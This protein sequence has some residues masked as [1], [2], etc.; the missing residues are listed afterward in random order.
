MTS[1]CQLELHDSGSKLVWPQLLT[2]IDSTV[3]VDVWKDQG[4]S[5]KILPRRFP[6][7]VELSIAFFSLWYSSEWRGTGAVAW[8]KR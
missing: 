6:S 1:R 7:T 5:H 8:D 3:S 4:Y 2:L